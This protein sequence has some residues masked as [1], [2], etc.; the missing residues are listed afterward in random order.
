[1]PNTALSRSVSAAAPK[2]PLWRRALRL[3]GRVLGSGITWSIGFAIA[4]GFFV[5]PEVAVR[6]ARD[7]AAECLARA[8]APRG[9][10]LPD[11]RM[12]VREF[13]YPTGHS[14][15]FKD[16]TYR[17]EELLARA[18]MNRYLDAAIGDP[19][20]VRLADGALGVKHMQEVLEHGSQ[21]ISLD[22]LGPTVMAPHMGK[23]A[24][25]YGDRA[26]L[27]DHSD[28]FGLWYTRKDTLEAAMLEADFDE[29]DRLAQRWA[30][31]D[32]REPDW[33]ATLGATLCITAPRE[34]LSILRFETDRRAE[35]RGENMQRNFGEIE[36]V[37][38]SCAVAA[39]EDVPRPP[40]RYDAGV[41][42]VPEVR[43]LTSLRLSTPGPT[44]DRKLAHAKDV[45]VGDSGEAPIDLGRDDLRALLL[46]SV[47]AL[48]E[49]PLDAATVA[50]LAKP[51][52]AFG[53]AVA[54]PAPL[55]VTRLVGEAPG[56]HPAVPAALLTV[57]ASRFDA[58]LDHAGALGPQELATL[59][60]AAGAVHNSAAAELAK[61]GELATAVSHAKRGAELLSLSPRAAALSAASAAW[62]AGDPGAALALIDEAPKAADAAPQIDLAL[63]TLEALTAASSGDR[64]RAGRVAATLTV[65]A[66][67]SDDPALAL[68]ARWVVAAFSPDALVTSDPRPPWSRLEWTGQSDPLAR[69]RERGEAPI[70]AALGAWADAL[71]GPSETR[72]AFRWALMQKRGDMPALGVPYMVA[73]DA[74]L[75]GDVSHDGHEVWL[76]ALGALDSRR[77]RMRSYAWMRREAA[78]IRGDEVYAAW[79]SERLTVL[80]ALAASDADFEATRFLRF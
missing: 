78:R 39:E 48:S 49:P 2:P 10:A 26:T 18:A 6:R 16:A 66:K 51:R 32:P 69:W 64:A 15:T 24:A 21:R 63:A 54:A 57:A 23:L 45:L 43:L 50:K 75:D 36:A 44:R 17:A 70:R 35:K 74:L 37:I 12:I 56:L 55:S 77:F 8:S 4:L 53:E 7:H 1:M 28:Y 25:L 79:W 76:D 13:D 40:S 19:D 33:R 31:L 42:D 29:V 62:V 5:A 27:V 60:G 41:A 67:A 73:G 30:S 71:V 52:T 20:P 38:E 68:E 47:V 59:R 3:G 46:A 80:R 61:S 14:Y 9:R 58:L 72:R 11:C 34:G 65:A 22:E